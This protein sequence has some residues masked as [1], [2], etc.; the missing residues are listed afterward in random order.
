MQDAA[1]LRPVYLETAD[2]EIH[3][4]DCVDELDSPNILLSNKVEVEDY[5]SDHADASSPSP[6]SSS[7]AECLFGDVGKYMTDARSDDR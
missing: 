3:E 4:T 5:D 2:G 7:P 1:D 6:R